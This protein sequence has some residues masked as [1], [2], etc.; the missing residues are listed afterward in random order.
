MAMK[1]A[2]MVM[3][4]TENDEQACEQGSQ[5]Y[6]MIVWISF[7]HFFMHINFENIGNTAQRWY[8]I[9]LFAPEMLMNYW[10][11]GSLDGKTL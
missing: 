10:N 7:E 1:T 3:V 8:Y 4:L 11:L 2:T 9:L 5:F 6:S